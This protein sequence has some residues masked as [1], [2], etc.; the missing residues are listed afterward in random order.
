M[1]L[2]NPKPGSELRWYGRADVIF[3]ALKPLLYTR[4]PEVLRHIYP[5]IIKTAKIKEG[6][7]SL[8]NKIYVCL[9][10]FFY[11]FIFVVISN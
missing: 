7:P 5:T 9:T 3:E 2:F 1:F 11:Y 4:E 8:A 6:D 10:Y